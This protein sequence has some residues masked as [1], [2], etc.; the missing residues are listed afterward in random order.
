M[1]T[2]IDNFWIAFDSISNTT[3]SLERIKLINE[4]YIQKGTE[5]LQSLIAVRNYQDHEYVDAITNYPKY[6]NSIR[7]NTLNAKKDVKTITSYIEKLKKIY[8]DL[9]PATIYFSI[10]VFRSGGTYFENNV[11][12]GGEFLFAEQN[13]VIDELPERVQKGIKNYAP[14][15][16]PLTALH[17]YIHTQQKPWEN[18]SIIH[19]CVAEG[20]AEF[21]STLIAE[22]P[23]SPPVKFGKENPEIVL[24]KFME[25]IYS[26]NDVW[27]W[28][29]NENQNELKVNDLG[30]YIGYEICEAHYN[31][32]HDKQKAIKE[33]IELDYGNDS[34]FEKFVN[35]TR[36][37]PLT[38]KEIGEKYES[39]LPT[40]SGI[41][42]FE[43]GSTSVSPD[44]KSL[45]IEFSDE[46]SECC[47]STDFEESEGV[48]PLKIQKILGWSEDKRS[49]SF[50]LDPL[51]PMTNYEIII[52]NFAK[53]KDGNRLA[54]YLIKF[55]TSEK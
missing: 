2:D 31:K 42:E 38:I 48:Y 46:M 3:D 16:I 24:S 11:L 32:A 34:I 43:N 15:D 41:V 19:L 49:F 53:E 29:W 36:F 45:T 12:L 4:L 35:D 54:P 20:V 26:N 37:L 25:E 27:N 52:S 21:V 5:G 30:Y 23:L 14:N 6:F 50:E 47:R 40:V 13:S 10:G 8:P 22:K 39:M 7:S 1:T 28:I 18:Y 51:K 17:E 33:L 9:K 44:L 55:S